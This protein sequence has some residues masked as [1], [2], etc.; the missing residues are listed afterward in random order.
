MKVLRIKNPLNDSI[1]AM[2]SCNTAFIDE[3]FYQNAFHEDKTNKNYK[4]F[5]VNI[6]I[7]K[8]DWIISTPEGKAFLLA[9]H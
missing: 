7:V 3:N 6:V 8:I 9:I 4:A 2:A 1:V 5:P